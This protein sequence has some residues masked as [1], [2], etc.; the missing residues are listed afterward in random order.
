MLVVE[1]FILVVQHPRNIQIK[2]TDYKY[3][4]KSKHELTSVHHSKKQKIICN[5]KKNFSRV[6]TDSSE[7]H[8]RY[9]FYSNPTYHLMTV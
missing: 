5:L 8:C 9:H 1:L 6:E 7:V 3:I 2:L 4:R